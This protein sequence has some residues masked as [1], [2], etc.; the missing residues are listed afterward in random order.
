MS[1]LLDPLWR[2]D[3]LL[4]F[5]FFVYYLN[6]LMMFY[7]AWKNKECDDFILTDLILV[8][9]LQLSLFVLFLVVPWHEGFLVFTCWLQWWT[10]LIIL[11]TLW[12]VVFYSYP[13]SVSSCSSWSVVDYF[14]IR[15]LTSCLSRN[16]DSDMIFCL[17]HYVWYHCQCQLCLNRWM[18]LLI[19]CLIMK[20][21]HF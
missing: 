3:I 4:I 19:P 5:C 12:R 8:G 17:F 20:I 7:Q 2:D 16:N 18:P 21:G 14:Q 13:I 1:F 15:E 6:R 9:Y 10:S 11:A